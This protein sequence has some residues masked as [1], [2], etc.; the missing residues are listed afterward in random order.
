MSPRFLAP[1][2]AAALLLQGTPAAH[3]QLELPPVLDTP[4]RVTAGDAIAISSSIQPALFAEQSPNVIAGRAFPIHPDG[5]IMLPLVG[6]LQVAGLTPAQI[7]GVL[8]ERYRSTLGAATF[9][10]NVIQFRR[11]HFSVLGEVPRA[12][13]FDLEKGPVDLLTALAQA[14]GPTEWAVKDRIALWRR[15]RLVGAYDYDRL[16]EGREQ[17]PLLQENDVV[18]VDTYWM[19]RV[20]QTAP[21]VVSALVGLTT[22]AVLIWRR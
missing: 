6:S 19:K 1:L 8:A 4:Y 11:F 15:G 16:K 17:P 18:F 9:T 3:A 14:G 5:T 2:L 13:Q 22:L 12:D 7:A 21:T 10:V 20:A